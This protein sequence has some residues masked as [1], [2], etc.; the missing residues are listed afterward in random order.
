MAVKK[1][2]CSFGDWTEKEESKLVHK[3]DLVV[4]P[5]LMLCFF[6]LQLDR[7]NIGNA[8]TDHFLVD[9]GITQNWFNVGQ[10]LLNTGIV[11]LEI[12]SNIV[13]Y[14]LGPKV[15]ISCQI[16]AWSLVA[17]FQA[18]QHGLAAFLTTRLLLGL[19]EAG[20]IPGGLYT[21]SL[22]YKRSELSKRFAL[23]FLGN[24]LATASGGLFA[25]G[26][27]HMRGVAGLTGW[28]WMFILEGIFTVLAGVVF[29]CL[30]PG[31][32]D[33][34]VSIIGV[35]YFSEAEQEILRMRIIRD[36][37]TK[38]IRDPHIRLAD[39]AHTL[40]D[41]KLWPHILL[42]I[43]GL[44]PSTAL[45]SYAPSIVASFGYNSLTA[46]AMTSIGQW[47][48]VLLVVIAGFIADRWDRRGFF[49]LVAVTIELAFTVAYRCLADDA[50]QGTKFAV[51]T[52]A[53]A[54]CS[55][56]HAVHGSWLSINAQSP[57]ER[58]IRMA[59]FIMSANCAGIV[60]G[61]L[62]RSDDLP[63]YHRGWNIAV[64][65]M[66]MSVICVIVLIA[67]YAY[68]NKSVQTTRARSDTNLRRI[69]CE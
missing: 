33:A 57:A 22:W 51:L 54:T 7:A 53:A 36:D 48:S 18:F 56:W 25:Y 6:A 1:D 20:F 55:W 38:E 61:Q 65:F 60:G 45:W 47:I 42:T 32:P 12:P 52:L 5:I 8:L 35:K 24:G 66:A 34:P 29:A 46:N 10:Q 67:L 40:A 30:F 44:A 43:I 68:S 13:L 23:F 69:Q 26:I 27:L 16:L 58:S 37:P 31:S 14:R 49:V 15:W 2:D 41:P 17:I 19:L 64:A 3:V 28:Q 4:M 11:L 9:V 21:L 50:K 39:I 63:Y 59:I 62:F